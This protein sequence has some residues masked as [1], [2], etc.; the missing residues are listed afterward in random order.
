MMLHSH[1]A[2]IKIKAMFKDM[3]SLTIYV[4]MIEYELEPV[5]VVTH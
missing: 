1:I 2:E 3:F 5:L 4:Q